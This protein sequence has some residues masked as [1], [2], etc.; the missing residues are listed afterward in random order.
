MR[1]KAESHYSGTL[2][3]FAIGRG[4]EIKGAI[5]FGD[6]TWELELLYKSY[7]EVIAIS[8]LQDQSYIHLLKNGLLEAVVFLFS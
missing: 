6:S 5:E 2:G 1:T 7:V 8:Y 3:G 4:L